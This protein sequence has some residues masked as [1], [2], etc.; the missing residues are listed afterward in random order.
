VFVKCASTAGEWEQAYALLAARYQARGYE[1]LSAGRVRF[2]PFHALPDTATLVA[3]AAGRVLATLSLVVDN[4]LLGLPSEKVY[5]AEVEDLRRQ[6]RGLSEVTCLAG[7]DLNLR[8]FVQVF[9]ALIRLALQ[10]AVARGC[11]TWLLTVNPRHRCFYRKA[12]GCVPLGPPRA[13]P[14][15]QDHPGEAYMLDDGLMRA[16]APRMHERVFGTWLP[17]SALAAEPMDPALAR[18]FGSRSSQTDPQSIQEILDSAGRRS[19]W[20]RWW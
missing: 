14:A 12:M 6:G 5:P 11:D 10:Y 1:P 4:S 8:Q 17:P 13:C 9:V 20:R 19:G 18:Y 2:T 7:R 15:V 3:L 16:N